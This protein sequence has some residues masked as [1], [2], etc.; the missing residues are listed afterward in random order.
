MYNHLPLP[1][2]QL[3]IRVTTD[4][5]RFYQ[6]PSGNLY[7]SVT[8]VSGFDSR[9]S[10][11]Q[12]KER[13]G[14]AEANKISTFAASR[15][16]R[17]HE[18]CELHLKNQPVNPTEDLTNWNKFLP[19]LYNIGDIYGVELKLYSDILG[20]AGTAD[21][22]GYYNGI[23]SVIDFKTSKK[24]KNLEWINGYFYQS[25]MYA[26]AFMELYNIRIHQ[27]VILISVDDEA[28]QEFIQSVEDWIDPT[29]NCI[30]RFHK[31]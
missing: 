6:T 5:G 2:K 23:L 13:I 15:G 9:K 3:A 12:W 28:P 19:L 25:T 4:K 7:P 18:L 16:T 31:G 8:T 17:F 22:I 11:Q 29:L 1:E 26:I 24:L 14:E 21:C 20:V 30:D 27:V 10:I